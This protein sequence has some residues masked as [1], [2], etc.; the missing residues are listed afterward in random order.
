MPAR[1][2]SKEALTNSTSTPSVLPI[3]LPRSTSMPMIS[4]EPSS[5]YSL[6]AYDASVAMVILPSALMAAG[7]FAPSALS[8]AASTSSGLG[9]GRSD[10]S[11]VVQLL[12]ALA[13]SPDGFSVV[14]PQ[15]AAS[16]VAAVQSTVST[17][18]RVRDT[19]SLLEPQSWSE[20]S[21][22]CHLGCAEHRL[23]ML[24]TCHHARGHPVINAATR[25]VH[26]G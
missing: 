10:G 5:V 2:P 17:D 14:A 23:R 1:M 13:L 20:S 24:R 9:S 3:A 18:R 15:P 8:A 12:P 19:S 7:T 25:A 4:S 16:S 6:G 11:P 26:P 21:E 22:S